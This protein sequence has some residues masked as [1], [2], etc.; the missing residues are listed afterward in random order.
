MNTYV[1][2]GYSDDN[3]SIDGDERDEFGCYDEPGYFHF[4][5]GTVV[6]IQYCPGDWKGWKV[7]AAK[8]GNKA[9]VERVPL[10]NSQDDPDPYTD[11]VTVR[12]EVDFI[13]FFRGPDGPTD[14]EI[15][16]FF[17]DFNPRG[18]DADALRAAYM[19]LR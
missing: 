7:E 4:S 17:A 16:D 2:S 9:T 18:C 3:A 1:M 19:I 15:E 11:K 5:D 10:D 14:E 12:G 8:T 13:G 6:S